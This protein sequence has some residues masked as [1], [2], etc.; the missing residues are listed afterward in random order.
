MYELR[1]SIV[2]HRI[3]SEALDET[4]I[5]S[6]YENRDFLFPATCHLEICIF[7]IFLEATP[8]ATRWSIGT[9]W[10][11]LTFY[12]LKH[13]LCTLNIARC[14]QHHIFKFLWTIIEKYNFICHINFTSNHYNVDISNNE[15]ERNIIVNVNCSLIWLIICS[16]YKIKI[17][18][19]ITAA[20]FTCI[21]ALIVGISYLNC[22]H[23]Q[24]LWKIFFLQ[25]FIYETEGRSSKTRFLDCFVNCIL[26]NI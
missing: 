7:C 24:I 12:F 6:C 8:T 5:L 20:N 22:D 1:N 4:N 14:F 17:H 23:V 11:I 25:T 9:A 19:S 26:D 21:L 16:K 18:T 13:I 15:W 2:F 10:L 3:F